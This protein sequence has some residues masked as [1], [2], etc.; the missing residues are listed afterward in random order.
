MDTQELIRDWQE[1]S[2]QLRDLKVKEAALRSAVISKLFTKEQLHDS[3]LSHRNDV[4]L[5]NKRKNFKV[6]DSKLAATLEQELAHARG[7]VPVNLFTWKPNVNTK[8]YNSLS[9][10]DLIK[11][12]K[13]ISWSWGLPALYFKEDKDDANNQH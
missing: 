4:I 11:A 6:N 3:K 10:E 1:A 8:S 13:V 9:A 12:A 5:L 7:G 2:A